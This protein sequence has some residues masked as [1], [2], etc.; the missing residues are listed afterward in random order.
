MGLLFYSAFHCGSDPSRNGGEAFA[1]SLLRDVDVLF[2]IMAVLVKQLE[3]CLVYLEFVP[4]FG[5]TE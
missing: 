4:L 1:V 5:H 2:C 3:I